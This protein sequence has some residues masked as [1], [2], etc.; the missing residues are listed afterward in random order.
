MKLAHQFPWAASAYVAVG[1]ALRRREL[2]HPDVP[3]SALKRTQITK[4]CLCQRGGEGDG[5]ACH[6]LHHH[7]Y[8]ACCDERQ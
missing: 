4:V 5:L 3:S 8:S 1:L 6:A 7:C 2:N